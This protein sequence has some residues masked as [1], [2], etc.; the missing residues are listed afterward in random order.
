MRSLEQ[1]LAEVGQRGA[2]GLHIE[3]GLPVPPQSAIQMGGA[4]GRWTFERCHR[5]PEP[6]ERR[7]HRRRDAA[8]EPLAE[9]AAPALARPAPP[10]PE[11]RPTRSAPVGARVAEDGVLELD[12]D[13]EDLAAILKEPG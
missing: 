4:E 10:R 9:Q 6:R 1:L 3:Q 11:P 2:S 12:G 5:W 13:H 8:R 7:F